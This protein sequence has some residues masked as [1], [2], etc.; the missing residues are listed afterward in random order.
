MRS[1]FRL[2]FPC[3]APINA[4]GLWAAPA[5]L[6]LQAKAARGG[7]GLARLHTNEVFPSLPL[8]PGHWVIHQLLESK[9]TTAKL[10]ALDGTR[11]D[12]CPFLGGQKSGRWKVVF[13]GQ[14]R[15]P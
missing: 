6:W 15:P 9:Q 14:P 12:V 2:H 8:W 11:P 13:V 7:Q 10:E 3:L 1:W 4:A 5:E